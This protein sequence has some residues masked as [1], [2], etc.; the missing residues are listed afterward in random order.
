MKRFIEWSRVVEIGLLVFFAPAVL[1]VLDYPQLFGV[2]GLKILFVIIVSTAAVMASIGAV[3]HLTHRCAAGRRMHPDLL[4]ITPLV[5]GVVAWR[6]Y[7]SYCCRRQYLCTRGCMA[8]PYSAW[9]RRPPQCALRPS[10]AGPSLA[11]L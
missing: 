11:G 2:T 6:W 8:K 9:R 10:G 7:R 5:L 4:L 3:V 1:A